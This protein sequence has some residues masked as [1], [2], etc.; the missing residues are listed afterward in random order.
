MMSSLYFSKKS[1]FVNHKQ[2]HSGHSNKGQETGE[3]TQVQGIKSRYGLLALG[4]LSEED[5][6]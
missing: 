5:C 6:L 1:C 3:E 2:I 4:K